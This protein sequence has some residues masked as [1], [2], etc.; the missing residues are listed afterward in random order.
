MGFPLLISIRPQENYGHTV[1]DYLKCFGVAF[2]NTIHVAVTF[3]LQI[4]DDFVIVYSTWNRQVEKLL[5][6]LHNMLWHIW[7]ET[8]HDD[9]I[10]WKHFLVTGPLWWESTG[11]FPSRRPA[12]RSFDVLYDLQLSKWLSKQSRRR[13]F[14]TPS[15]SLWGH[16]N[17]PGCNKQIIYPE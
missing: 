8:Y 2:N 1:Y 15:R 7:S 3:I 6:P 13:W 9:V 10:K 4:H 16:C 17:D 14:E 11:G 5:F 12:T